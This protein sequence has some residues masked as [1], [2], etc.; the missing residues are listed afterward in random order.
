[1]IAYSALDTNLLELMRSFINDP[2]YP[3]S[4]RQ[5]GIKNSIKAL[6]T[7]SIFNLSKI[8]IPELQETQL[9]NIVPTTTVVTATQ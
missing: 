8:D 3:T 7:G 5:K 9:Y 4:L 2:A 1:M 6:A